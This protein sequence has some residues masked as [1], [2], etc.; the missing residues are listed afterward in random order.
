MCLF[1]H[2][3]L[4]AGASYNNDAGNAAQ[5]ETARE[6]IAHDRRRRLLRRSIAARVRRIKVIL[7]SHINLFVVFS[8]EPHAANVIASSADGVTCLTLERDAYQ[9]LIGGYTEKSDK[10]SSDSTDIAKCVENRRLLEKVCQSRRLS[11]NMASL[12]L[13]E[14]QIVATLGIGGFG[15]VELVSFLAFPQTD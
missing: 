1:A 7:S 8:D 15:R 9:Q 5:V 4:F 3:S 6:G 11:T 13:S 10:H 14:L 12:Q 2:S